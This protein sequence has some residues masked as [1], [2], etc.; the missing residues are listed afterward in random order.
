M[1]PTGPELETPLPASSSPTQEDPDKEQTPV[2]SDGQCDGF[3]ET[4]DDPNLTILEADTQPFL[5]TMDCAGDVDWYKIQLTTTPVTLEITL[6]SLPDDS[7]FDIILYDAERNELSRS[8]QSG[9]VDETLALVVEDDGKWT[10]LGE[11]T[12]EG[13]D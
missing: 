2:Q 3:G 8:T 10:V 13:N 5:V 9:N 1:N 6:T 7:D 12:I 4:A 11:C